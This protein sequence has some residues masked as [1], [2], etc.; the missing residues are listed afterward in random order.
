MQMIVCKEVHDYIDLVRNGPFP[1]CREQLALCDLVERVWEN[2]DLY[3]NEEQ[4]GKYLSLQKYFP[5]NLFEWEVFVFALHNCLYKPNKQLRF[6]ELV[7]IGG[8]GM[9]K[10]GYISFDSFAMTT[11]INGVEDYHVDIFAT[12]EDQAKTSPDQIRKVLEKAK[13]QK[14]FY[15]NQEIIRNLKTGSK[16]RYR[17]SN[18]KTKDGGQPGKVVFDEY[19]GY[20]NYDLITVAETGLGKTDYSRK[21]IFSTQGDIRDGPLDDLLKLSDDILFKD[22]DDLGMLPFICKLDYPEEVDDETNWHK[23]NPSLRYRPALL[24]EIR[25]EYAKYK[26]NPLANS[27]FMTK[28]MNM[29]PKVK[30]DD[31]TAWENIEAT[32]RSIPD[33][34]GAS[35]IAAFDYA[36]TSNF[37]A[38]GLLFLKND[39]FYW[40]THSWVCLKSANLPRIKAPLRDWE[41]Q[42]HLTFVDAV[43]ISPEIPIEWVTNQ[44]TKYN[45]TKIGIDNFRVTLFRKALIDAGFDVD[46]KNKTMLCKRVTQMRWAPVIQSLFNNQR[47]VFGDNPLM[48]WYVNNTFAKTD[49]DGN[50]IFEKKDPNARMND[51]FMAFVA[52]ICASEGLE[53]SESYEIDYSD[54]QDYSY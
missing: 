49:K 53:D 9:G 6:P 21:M 32:K 5:F 33:L 19:H 50:I 28:R 23:A 10:N 7:G 17:T 22:A 12:A 2:E 18:P 39:I 40:I 1:S 48:R 42:G 13:L 36:K 14:K 25:R 20:E 8:R 46:D 31:V 51:G 3:L 4:L 41:Q 27:A 45:V 43:E 34:T 30:E 24:E 11:P 38:A 15:W 16:I 47:I 26:I 44:M 35:C 54:F 52:A 29:P 37:V